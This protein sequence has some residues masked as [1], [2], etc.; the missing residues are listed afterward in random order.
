MEVINYLL[1]RISVMEEMIVMM[2]G[3]KAL[4]FVMVGPFNI[5]YENDFYIYKNV[6][7]AISNNEIK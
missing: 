4:I 1:G 5:S 6:P 3:M 7:S 2:V